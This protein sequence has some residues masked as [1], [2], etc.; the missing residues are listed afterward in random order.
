ME[1]NNNVEVTQNATNVETPSEP[2]GVES[3]PKKGGSGIIILLILLILGLAGYICYDKF[4]AKSNDSKCSKDECNCANKANNGA[5]SPSNNLNTK[6]TYEDVAGVYSF[7]QKTGEVEDG[8]AVEDVIYSGELHLMVNGTYEYKDSI[9]VG[10]EG[11]K[12]GNYI[13]EGDSIILNNW[14]SSGTGS[15]LNI[16]KV[17]NKL[18]DIKINGSDSLIITKC[19]DK[20]DSCIFKKESKKIDSNYFKE[21]NEILYDQCWDEEAETCE[22]YKI[23]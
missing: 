17:P 4:I 11:G 9:S 16:S 5:E 7:E 22:F 10:G 15:G 19:Y 1:E 8:N 23:D 2:A 3:K 18:F 14:F 6:Y 13:I 21:I 12:I 20:I